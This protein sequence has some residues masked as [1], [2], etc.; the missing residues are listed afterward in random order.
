MITIR[1]RGA[2]GEGA[3]KTKIFVVKSESQANLKEL[4]KANIKNGAV[5][6][7]DEA[8]G[9]DALH[10]LYEM[11]RVNH[12]LHYMGDNGEC[13]NQAE[14]YFARFR[15]MHKGQVHKM[16]NQHLAAYANKCAYR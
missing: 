12:P 14:S 5:V 1:E 13:T 2:K 6:H 9:Y 16:S 11:K 7:A 15:R 3:S 8:T 4:A 10:A